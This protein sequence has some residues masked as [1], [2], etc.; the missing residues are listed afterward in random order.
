MQLLKRVKDK[1]TDVCRDQQWRPRGSIQSTNTSRWCSQ[2]FETR[3]PR[4]TCPSSMSRPKRIAAA[5]SGRE[6]V[7]RWSV[8]QV[9][10]SSVI[11]PVDRVSR[12]SSPKVIRVVNISLHN[13]APSAQPWPG[14]HHEDFLRWIHYQVIPCRPLLLSSS[15]QS[16]SRGRSTRWLTLPNYKNLQGTLQIST[17]SNALPQL[18]SLQQSDYFGALFWSSL[19]FQ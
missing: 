1:P 8:S 14:A 4:L 13:G 6:K 16:Q 5:S 9:T 17:S 2:L 11:T 12:K 18:G 10:S 7:C 3:Q 15:K 19:D